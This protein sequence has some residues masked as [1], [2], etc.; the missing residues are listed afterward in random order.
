MFAW[1]STISIL[2]LLAGALSLESVLQNRPSGPQEDT[3]D[4]TSDPLDGPEAG[5]SIAESTKNGV[6]VRVNQIQVQ[7]IG[8]HV[9]LAQHLAKVGVATDKFSRTIAISIATRNR[10]K[11]QGPISMTTRHGKRLRL[12]MAG[13][14]KYMSGV[15]NAEQHADFDFSENW[16][17]I[18]DTMAFDQIFPV[19]INYRCTDEN[20]KPVTFEFRNITP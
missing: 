2:L 11:S 3:Q 10:G 12:F 7:R 6:M 14:Q 8:T 13:N 15:A 5:S 16:F 19:T 17:A 1:S 18:P 4:R 9:V 20:E